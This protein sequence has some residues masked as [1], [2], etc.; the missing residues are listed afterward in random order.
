M[1]FDNTGALSANSW[2]HVAFIEQPATRAEREALRE[3]WPTRRPLRWPDLA[4]N[5]RSR[6]SSQPAGQMGAGHEDR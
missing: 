4:V 2:R 6:D 5:G 1:S 3:S